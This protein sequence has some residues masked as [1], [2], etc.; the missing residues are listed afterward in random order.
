MVLGSVLAGFDESNTPLSSGS[1]YLT[2][3]A[4]T[5]DCL[6]VIRHCNC[7]CLMCRTHTQAHTHTHVYG[8]WEGGEQRKIDWFP[9]GLEDV[10][11]WTEEIKNGL[12]SF[13]KQ[14][15]SLTKN[16][17]RAEVIYVCETVL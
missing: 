8:P 9:T 12:E 3:K 4:L 10:I 13:G 7:T 2:T 17:K 16:K 11:S 1:F 15:G 5:D 6:T 14:M